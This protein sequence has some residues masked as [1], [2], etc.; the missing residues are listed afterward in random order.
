ME[1]STIL[2]GLLCLALLV[3]LPKLRSTVFWIFFPFVM[4]FVRYPKTRK[5]GLV[6]GCLG[7]AVGGALYGVSRYRERH[8]W[9][10]DVYTNKDHSVNFGRPSAQGMECYRGLDACITARDS[11]LDPT[12][13]DFMNSIWDYD[14]ERCGH[15]YPSIW[16]YKIKDRFVPDKGREETIDLTEQF[17]TKQECEQAFQANKAAATSSCYQDDKASK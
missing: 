6:L 7:L 16:S 5:P 14:G 15:R 1:P 17:V 2:I 8:Y 11:S 4:V 9:Y 3:Y 12:V 10:C 13:A